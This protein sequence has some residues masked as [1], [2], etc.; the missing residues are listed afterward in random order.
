MRDPGGPKVALCIR[1]LGCGHTESWMTG[2]PYRVDFVDK[3]RCLTCLPPLPAAAKPPAGAP[4][5]GGDPK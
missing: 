2:D 1:I 4:A 5:H 3:W